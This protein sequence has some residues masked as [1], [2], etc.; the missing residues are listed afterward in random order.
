MRPMYCPWRSVRSAAVSLALLLALGSST[1]P[2]PYADDGL[3]I[4]PGGDVVR[5]RNAVQQLYAQR[6]AN[7]AAVVKGELVHAGGT[8]VSDTLVYEWGRGSLS[9]QER[10]GTRSTAGGPY[11]TVWRRS[12]AGRWQIIRNLVF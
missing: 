6:I 7:I 2:A 12:A 3:F 8:R 11:L 1:A 5:G 9:V 4:T 10:D